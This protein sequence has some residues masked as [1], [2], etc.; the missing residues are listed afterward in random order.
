MKGTLK[1]NTEKFLANLKI[2]LPSFKNFPYKLYNIRFDSSIGR[3]K[4]NVV[5]LYSQEAEP[6]LYMLWTYAKVFLGLTEQT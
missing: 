6:M 5:I 1:Y 4:T 3:V 2:L